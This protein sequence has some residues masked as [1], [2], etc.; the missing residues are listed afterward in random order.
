MENNQ[1]F[2][3]GIRMAK[4]LA[5]WSI[6]AKSPIDVYK[7]MELAAET[8]SCVLLPENINNKNSVCKIVS[9][10]PKNISLGEIRTRYEIFAFQ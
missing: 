10:F 9:S 2:A 5:K 4:M 1:Q 7:E 3:G 8:N 6:A